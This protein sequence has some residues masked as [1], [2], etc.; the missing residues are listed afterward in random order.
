[1]AIELIE[2]FKNIFYN[3]HVFNDD[4]K[5]A[6]LGNVSIEAYP[7]NHMYAAAEQNQSL[8]Y[9]PVSGS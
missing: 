6:T 5:T 9:T 1:M 3:L 7:S 4:M 8:Y 2:R